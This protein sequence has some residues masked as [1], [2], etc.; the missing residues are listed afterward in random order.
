MS[1][2]IEL[3]S[4]H[5]NFTIGTNSNLTEILANVVKVGTDTSNVTI[6]IPQD[7]SSSYNL[8]L[9]VRQGASGESLV[10]GVDG[11]LKWDDP[12]VLKQVV[13]VFGSNLGSSKV[14]S[15]ETNIVYFPA[16]YEA[17]ITPLSANTKIFV[18]FKVN[19]RAALSS[20]NQVDFYIYKYISQT[21]DKIF[22]ETM[23]GP[24]IAAGGFVGQYISN[25]IDEPNTRD[26]ITY[27]LG[28][29]INGDVDI[30]D[31]LGILGYDASYNNTIVLQ[32]FEGSGVYATSVWNKGA[33]SNGLYYNDGT[34]HI[35][36][37][38]DALGSQNTPG[39]ALELSGNLVG[40]NANFSGE[41]STNII[42]ANEGYFSSNTLY[43][44]NK[45]VLN[46]DASGNRTVNTDVIVSDTSNGLTIKAIGN[47]KNIILD[48]NETGL[49]QLNGDVQLSGYLRGPTNMTI[50]PATHDDDTGTLIVKGNLRV[51]G[52]TTT[53]NSETLTIADS[54]IILNNGF[55]GTPSEN[56]GIEIER[57]SLDNAIIQ[58]NEDEGQWEF[59]KEGT[60]LSNIK[61]NTL[62]VSEATTLGITS[63]NVSSTTLNIY[64]D[65]NS[66]YGVYSLSDSTT[67][68]INAINVSDVENNSQILIYYTNS[69]TS[70][71]TINNTISGCK[72]NLSE[73]LTV[74]SGSSVLFCLV[75][76]DSTNILTVSQL[77]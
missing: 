33:D 40:T 49:I 25:L 42:R 44:N 70:D 17:S 32:E 59:Y 30:S 48:P 4:Q 75:N 54:T 39:V 74:S 37:T 38:K 18:Q 1:N 35:G 34:V 41:V 28:Y 5:D 63:A 2:N 27:K 7:I 72:T 50:D 46:E 14:E 3:L 69:G 47:N 15:G 56:A 65:A 36:S 52:T 9:P 68:T 67:T 55:S 66:S 64:G 45:P 58:W 23:Y 19:Y 57:G 51:L 43:I 31:T 73:T 13:T 60:T 16:N 20:D 53:I 76:I 62:K 71:L 12:T 22:S 77:Y 6:S 61:C 10:Y 8:I 26:E 29:K 24:Y 21:P 11:Q